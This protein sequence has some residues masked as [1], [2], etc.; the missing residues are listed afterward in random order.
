MRSRRSCARRRRGQRGDRGGARSR[1]EPDKAVAILAAVAIA[2][3]LMSEVLTDAIE[4]AA[5]SLRA[6]PAVRG[7]LPAGPGGERRRD[8]QRHPVR[9]Q[10]SDGPG[11]RHHGRAPAPRSPCWSRRSWSWPAGRSGTGHEPPVL[12]V[13]AAGDRRGGRRGAE[14]I[15]RRQLELDRGPDAA[16][17]LRHAGDRLLLPPR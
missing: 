1:L 14:P 2:L 13:R 12:P 10:G 11:H 15:L 6:H 7:G 8:D 17:G 3:A 9:P 16:G 5:R 4:P